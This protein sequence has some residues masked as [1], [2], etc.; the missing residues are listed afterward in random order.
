MP[1]HE[2]TVK[3]LVCATDIDVL[4]RGHQ[5]IRRDGYWA[6][7]SPGNPSFWWGNFLLFDE[8]PALGDGDRW[9]QL[10]VREF[11]DLPA[12]THRTFGWDRSDNQPGA[13][14]TEFVPRGY[15]LQRST[16]LIAT[17]EALV[18]HPRENRDVTVRTL[19]S[20]AGQDEDLWEQVI[21]VQAPEA[22]ASPGG[23]YHLQFLRTRQAAHRELFQAGRGAWFVALDGPQVVASLGIVVTNGRARYQHVDTLASHRRRGIAMR[24][25][26]EAA[27]LTAAA[28]D[29]DHF[30]IVADP[31]YHAMGIYESVGFRQVE[32][33]CALQLTPPNAA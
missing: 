22:L 32:T 14:A 28:H 15:Q 12:V 20:A 5:L 16:G 26:V 27:R 23:E 17:P 10:F 19:G 31:G 2:S 30:V 33:V 21:A 18:P 29:I 25:V 9:E 1:Q 3:S 6:V 7:R 11:A 4:E 24:L 13:A 8:P